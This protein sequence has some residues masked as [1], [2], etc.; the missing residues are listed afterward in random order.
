MSVIAF[1]NVSKRYALG[2][3]RGSLGDAL[4]SWFA[5]L[6][7]RPAAGANV[8]WAL[9]DVSFEVERGETLG[10]VGVNGAG[11]STIL[12]VLSGVTR[13]TRGSLRID[14]RVGALIEVGAGFH[15]DL[16]GRENIYLNGAILGL[17]RREIDAKLD[18]IIAFAE[19]AQFI[20][21][22][23]KRYSSGM[24]VRLGFSV[25]VHI[26]PDILLIDE[27]LAVGDYAFREKCIQK[28]NEFRQDGRTMIVV[29]HDRHMLEKL[30]DRA[31]LLH[32]GQVIT[33]GEVRAV[34]DEYHTGKYR[35]TERELPAGVVGPPGVGEPSRPIEIVR[36]QV[37][38]RA[39][40][41]RERF[42]TG[43]ACK[44]VVDF[45][46]N[47][48]AHEPVFYCD[49][50]H[51][52]TWVIGTNNGRTGASA[53]FQAGQRGRV[54]MV[55]DSLNVLTGKYH[56]DVGA[57]S[58]YFAWRPYHIVYRAAEFEVTSSLEQGAGLVHLPHTWQFAQSE[59]ANN[60]SQPQAAI[61]VNR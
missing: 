16:T 33:S 10:L 50:H 7:R 32:K 60:G 47:Q 19:L 26:D 14:G 37:A 61:E 4:A 2:H 52:F 28:I 45:V 42:L 54:E 55:I 49:I 11:K 8:L 27:V 43:E 46:C 25:A 57:V 15:P 59:A 6:A 5:F 18:S 44:I 13:P 36:V 39:G 31:L 51:E 17:K 53:S 21:T 29:S 23:V 35:E 12:K 20:D 3:G 40:Q 41:P 58:D 38:D 22:P 34:L 56:L 30:C 48:A 9:K 24:Y 1:N